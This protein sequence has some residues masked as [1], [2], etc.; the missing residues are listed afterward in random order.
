MRIAKY[1]S[2]P[3]ALTIFLSGCGNDEDNTIENGNEPEMNEELT[4]ENE[5]NNLNSNEN[6]NEDI[7][8]T[9]DNNQEN[10]N[11]ESINENNENSNME[12][13]ET[14]L[15]D[16]EPLYEI[17]SNIAIRPIDDADE[18]IVLLTIDDAPDNYGPEMA[19]ILKDLDA[20]AIFFVNGHFIQS[21]EG[22]EQLKEIHELG[23]EIGN[24][25][26][27]HPNLSNISEEEQYE[28]IVHLNDLIEEIIGERPRF[29]RAPFGVNTDYSKELMEDEGMQWMNWSYGYDWE[30]GYMEK[31]ALEEIM[32]EAPALGNGA[33][34][35]MHDREFTK[36]ALEG[37]VEGLREKG[38]EIVDPNLIK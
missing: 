1:F 8:E 5:E 7:N 36:D 31:E 18:E 30:A 27:T 24:H 10:Q 38:Y 3:L 16:Q 12:N 9:N 21:E 22:Q 29:F 20:G 23:F 14:A 13:E 11:N 25:T 35:L 17:D 19:Q 26:M 32:V 33:N 4:D 37:I 15:E 28:E 2:V 6:L 34:L